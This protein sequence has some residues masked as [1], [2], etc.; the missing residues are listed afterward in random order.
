MRSNRLSSFLGFTTFGE[1]HGP[2][3]GLV[4]EDILPNIPFPYEQLKQLLAYRKPNSNPYVSP[5]DEDDLFEILSGVMDGKTTGMPI[6][7][8]FPNKDARSVDYEKFKDVFRPGHA[9]YSLFSKFKI[10][11]YRGGGRASGRETICRVASSVFVNNLLQDIKV[12]FQTVQIGSLEAI[13]TDTFY[14]ISTENPFCWSD[15]TTITNLY[16]Y[17]DTIKEEKET[18]GGIIRASIESVPKGLGEPVFEKLN[19]CLA[20]AIF[21]I[22]SIKGVSFGDGFDLAAQKGS[23]VNDQM[24]SSGFLSNHLGGITG[25]VSTGQPIVINI[26]VKPISAHGKPQSTINH[27]GQSQDITITGRHDICHIPRI[28]PV[29]EAMIKLTLADS[30][31]HQ[32][33]IA[34][35]TQ[36]LND[37][38]EALDKLDE[39]LLLLVYRR[40]QIVNQVKQLKS[41]QHVEFRDYKRENELANQW[42]Q[43]ASV[44]DLAEN[45]A[46]ELLQLV[47]KICRNDN[48]DNSL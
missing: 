27:L 28:L 21:S 14:E 37:Y 5:R 47:L 32:K 22:G 40:K 6:C 8:I 41:G 45:D 18:V 12:K 48:T 3:M 23:F 26:A 13:K 30:I 4:I 16:A 2:A 15:M 10:Y 43:L 17:L 46:Q 7:I 11:D 36:D 29:I 9:D 39:D 25:G 33:L 1:S 38:R 31:A 24:N 34:G 44:M 19:A 42:S 35:Q 20:K